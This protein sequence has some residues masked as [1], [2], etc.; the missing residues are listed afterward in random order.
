MSY[1]DDNPGYRIANETQARNWAIELA[2][3]VVNARHECDL[4]QSVAMKRKAYLIWRTRYGGLLG[5]LMALHRAG[6]LNDVA[7]NE[8][9]QKALETGVPT[10]ASHGIV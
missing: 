10:V 2:N 7:Y 6:L 8:L 3:D 1:A 9:R 4:H 5:V